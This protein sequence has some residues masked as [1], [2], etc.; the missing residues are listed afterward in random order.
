MKVVKKCPILF[1]DVP[2]VMLIGA[3]TNLQKAANNVVED[4]CKEDVFFAMGAV[5]RFTIVQLLIHG[6]LVKHTG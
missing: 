5:G 6:I 1:I 4:L 3:L 2:I